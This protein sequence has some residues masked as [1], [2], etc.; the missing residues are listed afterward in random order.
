MF[1]SKFSNSVRP[2]TLNVNVRACAMPLVWFVNQIIEFVLPSGKFVASAL[3]STDTVVFAP[4]ASAPFV[5][6]TLSHPPLPARDQLNAFVPAFSRVKV[7]GFGVNGPPTGPLDDNT[8]KMT[9]KSSSTSYASTKPLV[10][11]LDGEVA[12]TPIPRLANAAHNCGRS[13]PP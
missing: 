10:V 7:A 12:L 6:E 2:T 9:C 11:E 1:G 4:A 5:G 3:T 8:A 13:A